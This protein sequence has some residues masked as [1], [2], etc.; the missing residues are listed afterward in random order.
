MKKTSTILAIGSALALGSAQAEIESSFHV[1]YST[2]YVFRGV[3][4]AASSS[5]GLFEY[6][7]D[8][9]GDCNCGATWNA[10]IWQ[11]DFG[12]DAEELD[13]YAGMSKE[14]GAVELSLGLIRY[15]Y[16]GSG[17]GTDT[18]EI[19]LGAGTDLGG[20]DASAAIYYDV[21]AKDGNLWGELSLGKSFD[22]GGATLDIAANFGTTLDAGTGGDD[23]VTYGL[24][25][26]LSKELGDNLTGSIYIAG[27]I[28]EGAG[29][30]ND[31]DG[32]DLYGG[33]SLS[34]GF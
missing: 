12:A 4:Q 31:N 3:D 9:T 28:T 16:G 32:D 22:V 25:A 15:D 13:I 20:L 29:V 8:F 26:A 27:E 6:G 19:F 24:S 1:G 18:S 21:D 33:I 5:N 11:A 30:A 10:G 7:L 14:F 34:Y 17:G 2:D 23:Y